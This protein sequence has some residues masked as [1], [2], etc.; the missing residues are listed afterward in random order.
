MSTLIL[1][2]STRWGVHDIETTGLTDADRIVQ[3]GCCFFQGRHE[4]DAVDLLLDPGIPIP[5]PVSQLHGITTEMV[6]GKP[7]M[8]QAGRTIYEALADRQMA[9][10]FNGRRF[11]DQWLVRELAS[12]GIEYRP[13]PLVDVFDFLW[14]FRRDAAEDGKGHK[15]TDWVER[16]GLPAFDAHSAV[17]DCAATGL[18]LIWAIDQGIIPETIEDACAVGNA[19][20]RYNDREKELYGTAFYFDRNTIDPLAAVRMGFGKHRG[21]SLNKMPS[22][23]LSWMVDKSDQHDNVKEIA[24]SILRG[25]P[26][27]PHEDLVM[28]CESV[29]AACMRELNESEQDIATCLICDDFLLENET[30]AECPRCKPE[31]FGAAICPICNTEKQKFRLRVLN[32]ANK[33]VEATQWSQFCDTCRESLEARNCATG[34]CWRCEHRVESNAQRLIGQPSAGP[35]MACDVMNPKEIEDME[36]CPRFSPVTPQSLSA[37]MFRLNLSDMWAVQSDPDTVLLTLVTPKPVGAEDNA[38]AVLP[39]EQAARYAMA[40]DGIEC[41]TEGKFVQ[42]STFVDTA[43][44]EGKLTTDEVENPIRAAMAR[45][46]AE[47]FGSGASW[48]V[49][50]GR[51]NRLMI[52]LKIRESIPEGLLRMT[53]RCLSSLLCEVAESLDTPWAACVPFADVRVIALDTAMDFG[54]PAI[55]HVTLGPVVK[56]GDSLVWSDLRHFSQVWPLSEETSLRMATDPLASSS[57]PLV[58]AP[59]SIAAAPTGNVYRVLLDGKT[60]AFELSASLEALRKEYAP[61]VEFHQLTESE[62][63][64][65]NLSLPKPVG[66]LSEGEKQ[67]TVSLAKLAES[68][69]L[70]LAWREQGVVEL[71]QWVTGINAAALLGR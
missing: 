5:D 44:P 53:S 28:L 71:F 38:D 25:N 62:C 36:A 27:R 35:M 13:K 64:V 58:S 57:A 30:K 70:T 14:Y 3:F 46:V 18:L 6:A 33:E 41:L 39:Q 11:D 68:A 1:D 23:Y 19:I 8:A 65:I 56:D 63:K 59:E 40:L 54:F 7:T 24:R 9:V 60:I 48:S 22:S 61:D 31:V 26:I 42:L 34:L 20:A 21:V 52:T 55:P 45:F 15:L 50:R 47:F 32:S 2:T 12:A 69:K 17:A 29:T 10:A 16:A 51:F 66:G 49:N 4:Q 43:Q 67:E 37:L